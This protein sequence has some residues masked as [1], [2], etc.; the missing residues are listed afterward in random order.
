MNFGKTFKKVRRGRGLTIE[1][2]S[3]E[4][5]SKSTISRFE[6]SEADITLEKLIL[7]LNKVKIS[8]R[9]FVF[10]SN[11]S[12]F[13]T[14]L[15]FLS[16]AVL[17]KDVQMLKELVEEEW[18]QFEEGESNYSKLA[19]IVLE[20]HYR[21]LLKEEVNQEHIN[22]LTDYLFQC[23]IW[24][25]F[26]LVLFG[27]SIAYLPIETSIV[28]SKELIKKTSIFH[29]DRQ[30]FETVINTIINMIMVCLRSERISEAGIFIKK[31]SVFA[32][33]ETFFLEKIM[34]KFVKG[35]YLFKEGQKVEG[36][37]MVSE[38]LQAMILAEAYKMEENFRSFYEAIS[39]ECTSQ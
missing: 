29:N 30:V 7:L 5:I 16:K 17:E 36:E 19:A 24:T 15:E 14:S 1:N 10:L 21:S 3:D 8:M 6:R 13:K 33:D 11:I 35:V 38:A 22:Y 32:I 28:L 23:D 26:D 9:E 31:M 27:N 20:M 34:L 25:Q 18:S 2:L 37:K 39:N 12:T 4:Y